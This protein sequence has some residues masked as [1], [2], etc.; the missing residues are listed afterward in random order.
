MHGR[1]LCRA[2]KREILAGLLPSAQR[3]CCDALRRRADGHAREGGVHGG[4]RPG[5]P[6]L[7]NTAK[8]LDA[9]AT[10]DDQRD[11]DGARARPRF[12]NAAIAVAMAAYFMSRVAQVGVVRVE[13][14]ATDDVPVESQVILDI[15]HVSAEACENNV[16]RCVLNLRQSGTC[17]A[18]FGV[19]CIHRL[20]D[21]VR[22]P[23]WSPEGGG[24]GLGVEYLHSV[25]HV[26]CV[27]TAMVFALAGE[28]EKTRAAFGVPLVGPA[29]GGTEVSK[30]SVKGFQP[31]FKVFRPHEDLT[32]VDVPLVAGEWYVG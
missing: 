5:E 21:R 4:V 1:M 8:E 27:P 9:M 16:C 19:G 17:A 2:R 11:A 26:M 18:S 12:R 10:T 22:A 20:G 6:N 3:T 30:G 7:L 31:R 15:C 29:S 14:V 24:S 32:I 13:E 23:D 25:M 28:A